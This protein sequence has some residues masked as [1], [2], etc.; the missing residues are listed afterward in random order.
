MCVHHDLLKWNH[1]QQFHEI[2]IAL[3][4]ALLW[5]S[6]LPM[7]FGAASET[8]WWRHQMK[9]FPCY[10][11]FV[12]GIHRS[13]VNFPHKG[14][15]RGDLKFS[16]ISAWMNDWV[17]NREACDLRYHGAHYDVIVM[18][19]LATIGEKMYRS[20]SNMLHSHN[21]NNHNKPM[22]ISHG[23]YCIWN[24][25]DAFWSLNVA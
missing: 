23:I 9:Y 5:S 7:S 24:N 4:F 16:L 12:L 25:G 20:N 3:Y 19:T 21:K 17:N 15:W 6:D 18:A 8:L 10:W 22:C 14:Q 1:I 2:F 13:P 11:P